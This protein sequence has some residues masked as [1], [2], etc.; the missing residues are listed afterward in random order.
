[1]DDAITQRILE[2]QQQVT[3]RLAQFGYADADSTLRSG[4]HLAEISVYGERFA[5]VTLPL[6]LTLHDENRTAVI[7]LVLAMK[8]NL[9]ELRDALLDVEADLQNVVDFFLPHR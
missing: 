1:M 4:R 6:F 8:T 7:E 9:D 2:L 3:N 5:N